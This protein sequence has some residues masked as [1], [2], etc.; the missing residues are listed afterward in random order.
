[1]SSDVG[2][3]RN[4]LREGTETFFAD[5]AM[6]ADIAWRK[7][8]FAQA[9]RGEMERVVLEAAQEETEHVSI[10]AAL[11]EIEC[12]LEDVRAQMAQNRQ[13][14]QQKDELERQIPKQEEQLEAIEAEIHLSDLAAERSQAEERSL[15]N[16]LKELDVMLGTQSREE[17][18]KSIESLKQRKEQ[19][20]RELEDAGERYQN[21]RKQ[22]TAL[23]AEIAALQNQIEEG[24]ELKEEDAAL[25]RQHWNAEKEELLHRRTEQ[26][27]IYRKNREIYDHVRKNQDRMIKAE[28]EYLWMRALSDTANGTITGKRKM[29][30]ET[31]VQMTYFDRIIRRANLRLM[32][33]SCGQY[34]LKRQEESSNKKEKAGLELNVIDHFNG[35]ERSVKTLSGGETFE[36]SLSL[37]LGLSDEIQSCAGGI[38]LDTM[39]VDEGFGSLDDEALDRAIAAL[40]RLTEG[41]RMVGIISHVSE[42]RERIERKIV[43]TRTRGT[44]EIGSKVEVV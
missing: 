7:E 30:L 8:S 17:T 43:V 10:E 36:A 22:E 24:E 38:R 28:Q 14:Q 44:A 40:E 42:L 39:F 37:A 25:R 29:E 5:C 4:G 19:K 13:R 34:E 21:C 11:E 18:A 32:T 26:Y 16:E 12:V 15:K 9:M 2:Y 3:L 33:M 20:T 35:S 27:A 41:N 23:R 6:C 31:Y 1:M